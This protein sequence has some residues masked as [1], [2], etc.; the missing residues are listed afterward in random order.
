MIGRGRDA[1]FPAPPAQ[2]PACGTTAPGIIGDVPRINGL[3]IVK[4]VI[5][6]PAYDFGWWMDRVTGLF[7]LTPKEFLTGGEQEM[8]MCVL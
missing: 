8:A 2:I 6:E 5:R 1:G 3:S 4:L 7:G